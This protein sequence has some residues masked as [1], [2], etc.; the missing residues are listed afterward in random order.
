MRSRFS[1]PTFCSMS[2]SDIGKTLP[3]AQMTRASVMPAASIASSTA[4]SSFDD[5]VGRNWLSMIDG[6]AACR[7]AAPRS[8]G[9]DGLLERR[10]APPRSRRHG[11][12]LVGV[13]RGEQVARPGS[14]ARACPGDLLARRPRRRS[15]ADPSTRTGSPR[16]TCRPSLLPRAKGAERHY[17]PWSGPCGTALRAAALSWRACGNRAESRQHPGRRRRRFL[18][19]LRGGIRHGAASRR[20][21]SDS[22]CAGCGSAISSSI[23]STSTSSRP[24]RTSTSA[25]RSTTSRAPTGAEELDASTRASG[26]RPL[27][28]LPGGEVQMYFRDPGRQLP[29]D[30]LPDVTTLDRSVFGDDLK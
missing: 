12:G 20:R 1:R 23:S 5:G 27:F 2:D 24:T 25:S 16:G 7:R 17:R 28:E 22:R 11:L 18:P 13:D 15:S 8:A 21:T 30:R 3:F 10:R 26:S 6:D 9:R 29:G 14:R 19:L 4:G